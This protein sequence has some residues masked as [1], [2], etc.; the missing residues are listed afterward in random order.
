[1]RRKRW[2]ADPQLRPILYEYEDLFKPLTG[3]PPED[4]IQHEIKLTEG[5]QPIMK[6]PYRLSDMQAKGGGK[7]KSRRHLT[8]DGYNPHSRSGEQ[9]SL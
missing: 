9:L 3:V 8:K 1:M 4:R 6:R 2:I 7:D 5:A